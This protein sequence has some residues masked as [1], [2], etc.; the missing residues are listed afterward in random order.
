MIR[1][2]KKREGFTLIELMMVVAVIGILAAVLIPK[3]GSTKDTAKLAGVE[4][5]VRTVQS[6]VEGNIMRYQHK[7]A[8]V[9]AGFA[10]KIKDALPDV[11]NPYENVKGAVEDGTATTA[12]VVATSAVTVNNT[13]NPAP[14]AGLAANKGAVLVIIDEVGSGTD[15]SIDSVKI[16]GYDESGKALPVVTVNH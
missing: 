5:N 6:I 14:A 3:I 2:L 15:W 10:T 16:Y 1:V 4:S 8:S 9:L 7:N 13:D 12:V 11:V